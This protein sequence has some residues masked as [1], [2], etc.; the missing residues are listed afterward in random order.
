[1]GERKAEKKGKTTETMENEGEKERKQGEKGVL[2]FTQK[3]FGGQLA[4]QCC[5]KFW[6][7]NALQLAQI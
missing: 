6:L 5:P 2:S 4:D 3:S 1:M 7:K